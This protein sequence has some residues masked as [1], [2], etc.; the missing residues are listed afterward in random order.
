MIQPTDRTHDVSLTSYHVKDLAIF[1]ETLNDATAA[2]FPN[3]KTDSRY[4]AI[5]VLLLCWEEDNLGVVKEV[6]ELDDVFEDTYHYDTER[7]QIPS[8][9]SHNSLGTRLSKFLDDYESDE[10]LLIVY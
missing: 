3:D 5:H 2:A 1:G 8:R 4:K 7:W 6:S 9:R 10:N